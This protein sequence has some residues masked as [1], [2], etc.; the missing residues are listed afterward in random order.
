MR[1]RLPAGS[2]VVPWMEAKH[3]SGSVAR[4]HGLT[5]TDERTTMMLPD[6]RFTGAGLAD[7]GSVVM[8]PVNVRAAV[9]YSDRTTRA[10][11]SGPARSVA[12][13]ERQPCQGCGEL[14]PAGMG[15]R[16][17]D[18]CREARQPRRHIVLVSNEGLREA[19]LKSP[20]RLADVGRAL[21][22]F[23]GSDVD[24]SRV[25]R[26]LGLMVDY[27]VYRGRHYRKWRERIDIDTAER[28]ADVLGVERWAVIEEAGDERSAA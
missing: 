5:A 3:R 6:G 9:A 23:V 27:E 11:R 2:T 26:T 13:R 21:G 25:K 8:A 1:C 12:M 19:F 10:T 15:R 14:K 4:T 16:Y 24:T 18:A 20:M 22:W 28:I 7:G 17:C